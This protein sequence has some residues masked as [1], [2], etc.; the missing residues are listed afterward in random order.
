MASANVIKTDGFIVEWYIGDATGVNAATGS[1]YWWSTA[2]GDVT[3]S[4][5]QTETFWMVKTIAWVPSTAESSGGYVSLLEATTAGPTIFHGNLMT[6]EDVLTQTYDPPLR[7]RPCWVS[8]SCANDLTA[9]G[10]WLF[11]LA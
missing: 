3:A 4:E 7:C 10:K 6:G 5:G 9:G 1:L 8:T 11:H 2:G